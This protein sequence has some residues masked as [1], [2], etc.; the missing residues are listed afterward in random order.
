MRHFFVILW[1]NQ[2]DKIPTAIPAKM[3]NGQWMPAKT[4]AK[5]IRKLDIKKKMPAFLL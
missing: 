5:Q 3:S 2:A 4:L 1:T